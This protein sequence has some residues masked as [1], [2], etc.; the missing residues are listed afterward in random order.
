MKSNI[1]ELTIS[2]TL[3]KGLNCAKS[4]VPNLIFHLIR[5]KKFNFSMKKK[6][7]SSSQIVTFLIVSE[8]KFYKYL[9]DRFKSSMIRS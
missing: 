6:K 5:A 3:S 1:L 8:R 2:K 7:T 4:T 9:H